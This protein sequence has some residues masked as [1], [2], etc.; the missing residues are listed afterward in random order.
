MPVAQTV[1]K[2]TFVVRVKDPRMRLRTENAA[3]LKSSQCTKKA[4]LSSNQKSNTLSPLTLVML[5]ARC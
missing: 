5:V 1:G 2:L 4:A 3:L